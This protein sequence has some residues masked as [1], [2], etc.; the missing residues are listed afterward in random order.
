MGGAAIDRSRDRRWAMLPDSGSE[1]VG[2]VALLGLQTDT[3]AGACG[4]R[5]RSGRMGK[6]VAREAERQALRARLRG[7]WRPPD[8]CRDPRHQPGRPEGRHLPRVQAQGS[9]ARG[10]SPRRRSRGQRGLGPLARGV[11]R[12]PGRAGLFAA[13]DSPLTELLADRG[14]RPRRTTS[15]ALAPSTT[16]GRTEGCESKGPA[17]RSHCHCWFARSLTPSSPTRSRH[18]GIPARPGAGAGRPPIQPRSIGRAPGW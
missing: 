6:G 18:T 4:A 15:S 7:P 14:G 11:H 2:C 1:P 5:R 9:N 17:R 8:T 13:R 16:P 12:F 3:G 10:D